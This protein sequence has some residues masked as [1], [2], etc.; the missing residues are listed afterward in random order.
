M[1]GNGFIYGTAVYAAARPGVIEIT[2]DGQEY[3]EP[4]RG[5]AEGPPGTR[6]LVPTPWA[7]VPGQAWEAD[8]TGAWHVRVFR[9]QE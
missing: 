7:N 5:P 4:Y 8:E 3:G 6:H 1:T 9:H 2:E